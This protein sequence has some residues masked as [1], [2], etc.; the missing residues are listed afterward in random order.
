M[1]DGI[2]EP[3]PLVVLT[4]L[5]FQINGSKR[6]YNDYDTPSFFTEDH[7]DGSLK[8]PFDVVENSHGDSS[9]FGLGG[10]YMLDS[11]F[12]GFSFSN[13]QNDYGVP[14]EHAESD[15][16]IEMES[17]RFEFR[18]EIGISDSS[19]LTGINFT[20]ATGIINTA[21]VDG[22]MK[23]VDQN[24]TPTRPSYEKALK[25]EFHLNTKLMI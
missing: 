14:G 5:S 12:A 21:K 1:M 7:H 13:Y 11:G 18:S 6:D 16:L 8:G 9:S 10:S 24:G 2:T 22:K 25:V 20:L 15:T 4:K 23:G 3:W 19:W 17:D